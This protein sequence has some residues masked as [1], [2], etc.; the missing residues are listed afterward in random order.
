M[1]LRGATVAFDLDGTLVDTAPDLIAVLNAMLVE[2]DRSPV[3]YAAAR[4]LIGGG[5]EALLRHGF[6]ASGAA[7]DPA[8]LPDMTERFVHRYLERIAQ[9]SRA[10]DGVEEALDDLAEA[11][12]LLCVCTN[13]LTRL[14]VALLDQLG[15]VDRFA[16]VVG[17]D[18]TS[19]RKPD[20][21]HFHDAVRAAGGD[22]GRALLVGDSETDVSTAR[23]A[24]VPSVVVSF[25]Y[26][27]IAPE[28]L[29][30]DRL[31]HAFSDVPAAVRALLT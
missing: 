18:Q 11:G 9:E 4:R 29:G 19:A 12:A 17:P 24:G 20:A 1:I 25:G 16:A 5:A 6:E 23:A 7:L 10:F 28:R 27:E 30:G 13:K 22:P 2:A 8:R 14:S 21:A 31:V 26:T 3:S 15:L